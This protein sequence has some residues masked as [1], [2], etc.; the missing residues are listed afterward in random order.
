MMKFLAPFFVTFAL[1]PFSDPEGNAVHVN[2]DQVVSVSAPTSC[3]A[4][5]HAK[6]TFSSTFQCVRETVEQV[7][8]K[9]TK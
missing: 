6:I 8:E 5:A 9:L 7:I 1:V 2:K 4:R 3:D